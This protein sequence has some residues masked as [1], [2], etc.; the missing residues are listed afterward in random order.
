MSSEKNK[1][2]SKEDK[3]IEITQKAI[4]KYR[5]NL[6]DI[7]NRNNLINLNFNPRSNKILRIIDE[8]PNSIVKKLSEEK[9]F[10]LISLPA[11]E[12]EPKDEK[13]DLFKKTFEEE[14]L[15][16]EEYLN[17]VEEL[18]EKFDESNE[19]SQKI[20]RKLKDFV[21]DKIGLKKR[22]SPETMSIEEYAKAHGI[23]P[24]YEVPK[25]NIENIRELRHEDNNLQT[26]F[27]PDDL[28]R[29]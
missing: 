17:S 6:L 4:A 2:N 28:E 9:I 12:K 13:T 1:R 26:L 16:N 7:S 22:L 14:K 25:E 10:K 21:R 5:E 3:F 23:I 18:G 15:V 8:L 27:Y 24:N 20:I 11:P 19:T 29:S